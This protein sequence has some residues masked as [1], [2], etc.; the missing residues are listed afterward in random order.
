M[1]SGRKLSKSHNA[2]LQEAA[3][4][5]RPIAL[6]AHRARL[7]ADVSLAAQ[8]AARTMRERRETVK[9]LAE[10]Q[11]AMKQRNKLSDQLDSLVERYNEPKSV[12]AESAKSKRVERL[13]S[14]PRT[15]RVRPGPKEVPDSIQDKP[16]GQVCTGCVTR[17]D[18]GRSFL[19]AQPDCPKHG[20]GLGGA[21]QGAERKSEDVSSKGHRHGNAAQRE[22]S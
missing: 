12:A 18:S 13:K 6:K 14:Q 5:A 1:S 16:S 15:H 2:K 9:R 7:K 4:K 19:A 22:E 21:K 10:K 3:E 11:A 8:R 17:R 20:L